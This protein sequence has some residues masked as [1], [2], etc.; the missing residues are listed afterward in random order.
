MSAT[1]RLIGAMLCAGFAYDLHWSSEN[2]PFWSRFIER[3][4]A[5]RRDGSAA[6]DVAYVAAGRLDGYWERG[7]APW[8][9]AAGVLLVTEAGGTVTDYQGVAAGPFA[10]SRRRQWGAARSDA[11]RD[12]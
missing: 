10:R 7:I 11:G 1:T 2:L 3:S 9:I 5:V 4:Q 12:R 8:D 6:L